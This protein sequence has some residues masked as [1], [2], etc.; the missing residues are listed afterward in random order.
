MASFDV[1]TSC[2]VVDDQDSH[3]LEVPI[4]LVQHSWPFQVDMQRAG[5]TQVPFACRE[6]LGTTNSQRDFGQ[7]ELAN[8]MP[9]LA[10]LNLNA[11]RRGS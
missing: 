4:R 11:D 8:S 10:C 7:S 2:I 1:E 3:C 9:S 6:A 5:P